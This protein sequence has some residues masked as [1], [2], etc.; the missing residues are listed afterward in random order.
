METSDNDLVL[1]L[2]CAGTACNIGCKYCAEARKKQVSLT[3]ANT[4]TLDDI[5]KLMDLT[6][7]VDNITVLFHG[8]EP[9]LLPIGYYDDIIKKWRQQRND[10]YFG[11]QTNATLIDDKWIDFFDSYREIVGISISLDGSASANSNRVRK[12]GKS[13][14]HNVIHALE[15]LE[16]RNLTVGMIS[17]L[18]QAAMGQE[19]ELFKLI[20]Q[21]NNI[22]F[23]K[24]NPCY[25]MWTDGSVPEWGIF[26]NEYVEYV[27][28]FFDIMFKNQY[29][30][31]LDVEP[32]LSIIKSLEGI[33][34]SFCNFCDKKCNHFL[35][36]YPGGKVIACDNF[37]LDDGL[38]PYLYSQNNINE[39]L[40]KQ[41][42]PLFDQLDALLEKCKNCGYQ[43]IC[44]GGCLAVRRRYILYGK[45]GE[46]EL[47]CAEMRRMVEYIKNRIES[48]RM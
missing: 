23:L 41:P 33:E 8:G 11:F 9:L 28:N 25:D 10:V 34:N 44:H 17:T 12:N 2:K 6:A 43:S 18:T 3:N 39:L 47:Y 32:I 45:N 29:L 22:R 4:V 48:V 35:S 27:I 1:I 24:L 26:P 21:F 13:T 46:E 37:D 38:Y 40:G 36:V 31:R 20:S 19:H 42:Q 30:R 15:E 14:F 16:R 5:E 7:S